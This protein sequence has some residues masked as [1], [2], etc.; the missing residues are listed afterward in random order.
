MSV[1][2]TLLQMEIPQPQTKK[3]KLKRLSKLA[4]EEVVFTLQ[5]LGFSR[6]A[7]IRNMR[8]GEEMDVSI[9]LAGVAEPS[10]RDKALMEK[11]G[12]VT[13]ME[14]IKK[15][16]LPG[17]IADISREVEKLSGYRMSTLEEVKKN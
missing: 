8:E 9:V 10:L 1:L 4:G 15:L 12:A 5:E 11:Y 17:E 13:P 14:L 16:L 3:F 2:D 7:E 6:V